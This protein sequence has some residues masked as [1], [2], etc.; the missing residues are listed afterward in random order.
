M[1]N[2]TK[3]ILRIV[4]QYVLFHIAFAFIF[5]FFLTMYGLTINTANYMEM[6]AISAISASLSLII[7]RA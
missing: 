6:V 3:I 1:E 2:D 7:P 4:A 5:A